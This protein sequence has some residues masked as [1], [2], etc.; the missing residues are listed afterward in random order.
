MAL[1][2]GMTMAIGNGCDCSVLLVS[3]L[4]SAHTKRFSGLLY[5]VFFLQA[6]SLIWCYVCVY[7]SSGENFKE[8]DSALKLSGLLRHLFE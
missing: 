8:Q 7:F 6:T 2:V 5:A 3:V 4:I 1:T